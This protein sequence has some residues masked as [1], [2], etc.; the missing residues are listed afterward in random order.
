[1][2]IYIYICTNGNTFLNLSYHFLI[3]IYINKQT[4]NGRLAMSFF[5]YGMYQEFTTGK[6]ILQQ[7]GL[8][9]KDQQVDGF[10][11]A[12][13]FSCVALYPTISKLFSK[14]SSLEL[15]ERDPEV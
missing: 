8:V 6:S 13:L 2:C 1:M 10:V 15:K 5:F 3:D 4:L 11:F 7:V 14:L 9:N 12:L